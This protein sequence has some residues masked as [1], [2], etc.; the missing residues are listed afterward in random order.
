MFV[1]A[2]SYSDLDWFALESWIMRLNKHVCKDVPGSSKRLR[3]LGAKSETSFTYFILPS[4][5]KQTYTKLIQNYSYTS[6]SGE[7]TKR[8]DHVTVHVGTTNH[9]NNHTTHLTHNRW[10]TGGIEGLSATRPWVNQ[11]TLVS[12]HVSSGALPVDFTSSSWEGKMRQL[13]TSRRFKKTVDM[14]LLTWL[15]LRVSLSFN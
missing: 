11:V 10:Q 13:L 7:P 9:Y 3:T 12:S 6:C 14:A 4:E 5:F 8:S 1:E 2:R 15:L